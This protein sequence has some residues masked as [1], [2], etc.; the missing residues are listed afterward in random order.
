ML[1][2]RSIV[3]VLV[4]LGVALALG[5]VIGHEFVNFDDDVNIAHNPYLQRLSV[6]NVVHFWREAYEQLYIPLTYTLW[7]CLAAIGRSGASVQPAAFHATNLG[8]HVINTLLA[9]AMLRRWL[10]DDWGASAGALLFGLHPVQVEPVAWAMGTKDVLSGFFALL[11]IQKYTAFSA[12]SSDV[13]P[14]R[15]RAGFVL[16][17]LAYVLAMLS[18]PSVVLVPV[19]AGAL[20]WGLHGR[21]LRQV[22]AELLPWLLL[23]VP[24]VVVTAVVQPPAEQ[25]LIVP[26]W[27]RPFVA[28]TNILFYLRMLVWPT[29]LA[30]DY[31]RSVADIVAIHWLYVTGLVP[32]FILGAI[33]WLGRD[34]RWLVAAVAVFVTGL[35]PTL[36]LWTMRFHYIST[37]ADRFLYLGMIGPAVVAG[38]VVAERGWRVRAAAG[39]VLA[40]LGVAA[41][42]QI[43]YWRDSASLFE[44]NAEAFPSS[45]FAHHQ[46]GLALLEKGEKQAAASHFEAAIKLKPDNPLAEGALGQVLLEQGSRE[47]GILHLRE[48]VRLSPRVAPNLGLLGN[49]LCESGRP[50]EGL[51]YLEQ[52]VAVQPDDPVP[53]N[54]FGRRLFDR[55]R[56]REAAEHLQAALAMNPDMP[57]ALVNYGMTLARL[58]DV[59]RAIDRLEHAVRLQ[60]DDSSA[61]FDLGYVQFRKGDE[62]AA[63]SSLRRAIGLRP[64]WATAKNRLAWILATTLEPDLAD[65]N[66][67]LR[68]ASAACKAT[69]HN[70]PALLDTLAVA[71]AAT[72]AFDAASVT[73]ARALSQAEAANQVEIASG[74][75][76]RLD[77]YRAGQPFYGPPGY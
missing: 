65:R 58:G 60:P 4:A 59:V 32:V 69:G 14:L 34:R 27:Q 67:A 5:G 57:A 36:G 6:G 17:V 39:C 19:T 13:P 72:G 66:E 31:G 74:L 77:L 44:H 33:V 29:P 8:L 22:A 73:A 18:K 51:S 61:W 68:L 28:G 23:A 64:D 71:E 25:S 15:A 52:A 21:K 47:Q 70:V 41:F 35:L 38:R 55:G 53:Q 7:S 46:L 12:R 50:D 40:V 20:A 3:P 43:R 30:V 76:R 63:A 2:R 45:W 37:V 9:F 10:R 24:V 56:Y 11:A 48:A 16:A 1:S 62:R 49:A 75:R 42:A 26:V 54:D